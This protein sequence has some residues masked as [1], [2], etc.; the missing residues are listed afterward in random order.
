MGVRGERRVD[1]ERINP[2]SPINYRMGALVRRDNNGIKE[3][4][5]G[6]RPE[7]QRLAF[8]AS[9]GCVEQGIN[10]SRLHAPGIGHSSRACWCVERC[11]WADGPPGRVDS[12]DEPG[13]ARVGFISGR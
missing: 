12:G 6:Y 2:G 8:P 4:L 3:L 5:I 1:S 7:H 11:S 13:M 9:D 10:Y